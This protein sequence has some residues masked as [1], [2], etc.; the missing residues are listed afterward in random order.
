MARSLRRSMLCASRQEVCQTLN[1]YDSATVQA[2]LSSELESAGVHPQEV[3]VIGIWTEL[4]PVVFCFLYRDF[5][6]IRWHKP[7]VPQD[8]F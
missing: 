4:R 8:V 6:G 7:Q 3:T 1:G 2:V 5:R